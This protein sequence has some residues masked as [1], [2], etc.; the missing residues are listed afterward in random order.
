MSERKRLLEAVD[1][2]SAAM[3]VRLI[4]KAKNGWRGWDNKAFHSYEI[5]GRM[6][7]KCAVV[8]TAGEECNPKDLID[9]ANFAAFLH[10]KVTARQR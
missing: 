5:P 6:L 2:F 3:K 10:W 7:Q 8:F 1:T 9:I 4:D